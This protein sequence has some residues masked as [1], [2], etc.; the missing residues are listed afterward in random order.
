MSQFDHDATTGADLDEDGEPT[1][2]V[3]D[4]ATDEDQ[5]KVGDTAEEL[6]Q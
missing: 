2:P 5:V 3:E 6:E 4:T 1:E